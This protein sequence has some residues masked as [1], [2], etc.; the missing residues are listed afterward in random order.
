MLEQDGKLTP[1]GG[2]P[3]PGRVVPRRRDDPGPVRAECGVADS[4]LMLAHDG[5][6]PVLECGASE[7]TNRRKF[8]NEIQI[9]VV[10]QH[11]SS[12]G[13]AQRRIKAPFEDRLTN[14]IDEGSADNSALV[15][16]L[17]PLVFAACLKIGEKQFARFRRLPWASRRPGV[18]IGHRAGTKKLSLGTTISVPL[19]RLAHQT[20]STP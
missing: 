4:F 8:R 14:W 7:L 20:R 18:S 2:I 16:A 6:C 11:Q 1:S 3:Y 9:I 12:G 10:A 5:K 15:V 17:L 19:V 13:Q